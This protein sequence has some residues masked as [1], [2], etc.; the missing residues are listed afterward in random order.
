MSDL[1]TPW[2]E[3]ADAA[4]S[5]DG[6]LTRLAERATTLV[7]RELQRDD[8]NFLTVEDVRE[9]LDAYIT[10]AVQTKAA[11]QRGQANAPDPTT[12]LVHMDGGIDALQEIREKLLGS[13]LEF[14]KPI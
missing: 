13:R 12:R 10:D 8:A 7:E 9:A 1:H 4:A 11:I 14:R 3:A 6:A 5:R 2:R